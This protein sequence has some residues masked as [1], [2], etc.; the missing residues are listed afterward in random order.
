[1]ILNLQISLGQDWAAAPAQMP[2][3]L[4]QR[5]LGQADD[6]AVTQ[7]CILDGGRGY[8]CDDASVAWYVIQR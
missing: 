2:S 7:V 3:A 6:G 5:V 8:T 4:I 1:M